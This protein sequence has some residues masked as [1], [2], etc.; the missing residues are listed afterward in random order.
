MLFT[1]FKYLAKSVFR[2]VD[3]CLNDLLSMTRRE[4]ETR[5][6]HPIDLF[7]HSHSPLSYNHDIPS[8]LSN[9]LF[10]SLKIAGM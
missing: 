10:L 4:R 8:I 5:S 7:R 9:M 6:F 1:S 3:Y 2:W